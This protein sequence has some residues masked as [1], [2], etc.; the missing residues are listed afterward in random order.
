M[1]ITNF[2]Y[3]RSIFFCQTRVLI[4]RKK[5]SSVQVSAFWKKFFERVISISVLLLTTASPKRVKSWGHHPNAKFQKTHT[6]GVKKPTFRDGVNRITAITS[7][8]FSL[9]SRSRELKLTKLAVL[10][11]ALAQRCTSWCHQL[12][13]CVQTL[14][15][16]QR[17]IMCLLVDML[18]RVRVPC[19]EVS[20]QLAFGS[21]FCGCSSS[22][23]EQPDH[24]NT[25]RKS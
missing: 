3:L 2:W 14:G 21:S 8:D 5:C 23:L 25:R 11:N 13:S 19:W 20:Q 9:I 12:R 1:T 6:L 22:I 17:S 15:V 16:N 24:E 10:L 4:L 7:L 18:S